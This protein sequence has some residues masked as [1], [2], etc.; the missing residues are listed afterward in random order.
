MT[1]ED[2]KQACIALSNHRITAAHAMILLMTEEKPVSM[3]EIS[4]VGN[5]SSSN[6]TGLVDSLCKQDLVMRHTLDDDRRKVIVSIRPNGL[7]ILKSLKKQLEH[8]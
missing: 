5:F 1:G 2:F 3:K 8:V 6:A 7:T 4:D